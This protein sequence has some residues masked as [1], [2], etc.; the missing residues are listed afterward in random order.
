MVRNAVHNA[1]F[2]TL[3]META[4]PRVPFEMNPEGVRGEGGAN[5]WTAGTPAYPGRR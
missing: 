4:F 3:T 1:F 5:V 2:N